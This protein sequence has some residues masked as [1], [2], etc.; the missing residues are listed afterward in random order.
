MNALHCE[1]NGGDDGGG[2]GDDEV[3]VDDGGIVLVGGDVDADCDE[4]SNTG[5]EMTF[6][7]LADAGIS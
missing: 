3:A 2:E 5:A 1:I 7:M 4:R 6:D